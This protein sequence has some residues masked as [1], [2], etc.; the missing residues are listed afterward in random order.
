MEPQIV[1]YYNECPHMMNIVDK[2]NEEYDELYKENLVLKK[3]INF[4]KSK[5]EPEPDIK[6][7]IMNGIKFKTHYDIARVIHKIHKDKFKCTSYSNKK[8]YYLDEGEWKLS[9]NG[10][11]IRI[12]ITDSKNIFEQQLENYTNQID[13]MDL[14]NIESDDMYWMIAEYY[15]PNCKEI[16]EKYSKPR[17]SSYV[18]RECMELFYY[19]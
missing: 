19:K 11:E 14:D 15:I 1:D 17:F 16:I 2:M 6:I 9:D 4:L 13:E 10:V 7:L 5:Y 3:Q 18:L 8:W 12:A